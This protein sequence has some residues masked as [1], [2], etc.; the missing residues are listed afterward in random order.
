M[1]MMN[2]KDFMH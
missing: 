2:D 1:E